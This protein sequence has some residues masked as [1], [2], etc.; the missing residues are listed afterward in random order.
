MNSFKKV[1]QLFGRR[2]TYSQPRRTFATTLNQ[3]I[4]EKN[5]NVIIGTAV[6]AA[7]GAYYYYNKPKQSGSGQNRPER[8]PKN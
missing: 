6:V 5:K 2:L 4:W 8:G 1:P 3:A 7:A